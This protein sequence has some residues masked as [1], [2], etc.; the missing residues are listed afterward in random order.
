[1]YVGVALVLRNEWVWLHFEVLSTPRRG[2]RLIR[3]ERLR[4][5]ALLHWLLQVIEEELGRNVAGFMSG[6]H[7]HPDLTGEM[8]ILESENGE[9]LEDAQAGD[10]F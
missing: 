1:M 6:S 5:R 2:G 9:L 7:Q 8:F 10:R 3:P 4:L